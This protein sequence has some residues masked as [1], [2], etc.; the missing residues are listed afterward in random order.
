[1]KD[2]QMM[3]TSGFIKTYS[4]SGVDIKVMDKELVHN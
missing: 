1:M 3:S 4:I 2:N